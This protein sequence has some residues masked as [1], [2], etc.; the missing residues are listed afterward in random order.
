MFNKNTG[1]IIIQYDASSKQKW[2]KSYDEDWNPID[3][4]DTT[5][6][7]FYGIYYRSLTQNSVVFSNT[8][9]Q[10]DFSPSETATLQLAINRF[11]LD[12]MPHWIDISFAIPFDRV[13]P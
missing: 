5:G 3:Y 9:N 8:S 1:V 13:D 7:D 6:R 4:Y 12:N 10:N 2:A 11:T